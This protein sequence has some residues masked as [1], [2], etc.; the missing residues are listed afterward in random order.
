MAATDF[1]VSVGSL[2]ARHGDGESDW[3]VVS[4]STEIGIGGVGRGRGR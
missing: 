3:Y 2:K 4:L 1:E